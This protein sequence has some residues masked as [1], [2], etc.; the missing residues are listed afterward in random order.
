MLFRYSLSRLLSR[1]LPYW[2]FIVAVFPSVISSLAIG[3]SM[4][5]FSNQASL[6]LDTPQRFKPVVGVE[7]GVIALSRSAPN[8]QN[9]VFDE[10]LN[11]IFNANQLQGDMGTGL[12][13][14][15]NL[16][17]FFSDS[18]AVDIQMRYFQAADIRAQ[19]TI[20]SA[21]VIP[22]FFSVIP[23]TPPGSEDIFY[24]S[25]IRSF[26]SN[27]VFRTPYRIRL[28]TGFRFFEVDEIFNCIN[29]DLSS[30]TQTVGFFSKSE[31]TM[32]GGQVGAEGTLLTNGY[33]RIFGS[34]KW[35]LLNNDAVGSAEAADTSG[36]PVQAD[37]RDSISSQLLDFQLGGSLN[38]SRWFSIYGGYQG[39]VASD[40]A[41]ALEQS[42]NGSIFNNNANPV[43]TSDAQWH[44]FKISGM[45]TW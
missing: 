8:S 35:A 2:C 9:L 39:L 29:N 11:V 31:N 26:E 1:T 4:F 18:K 24:N 6:D 42:R 17:N 5:D 7:M 41:L 27:I 44:G 14:T 34:F 16:F 13:A 38:F 45:A 12:D 37:A 30:P 19:E 21:E 22:L 20:T 32:A 40:I 3:Q 23:L 25:Q 36:N 28:L 43:F 33:S 15:F 10:N